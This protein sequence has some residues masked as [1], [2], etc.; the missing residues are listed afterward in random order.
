M[1]EI[2]GGIAL[3][4]G[5]ALVGGVVAIAVI[6]MDLLTF[7]DPPGLFKGPVWQAIRKIWAIKKK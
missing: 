4:V 6:A 7:G 5:L 1:I 2:L 3:V